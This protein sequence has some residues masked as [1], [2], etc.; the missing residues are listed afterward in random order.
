MEAGRS[1]KAKELVKDALELLP[2]ERAAFLA[3]ECADDEEL[4]R[5]AESLLG[6]A[7]GIKDLL[8]TAAPRIF[9]R[10]LAAEQQQDL[11]GQSLGRYQ[12]VAKIGA[13][14]MGEVYRAEDNRLG[15]TVAIKLLPAEFTADAERV[16][17]FE[18]EARSASALNHPN[19]ITIH[20]ID[21]V[22][23]DHGEVHF[24]VTEL[25]EGRTLR[26]LMTDTRLEVKQTIEIAAQ[27]A[28]ALR[29]VHTAWIIHRDIK[30]ENIMVRA[31]GL[32]KVLD[33]GIAKLGDKQGV[34]PSG[35]NNFDSQPIPHEGRTMNLTTAGMILGTASYMS[36]EQARGELLDGRTDVFSLGSVLYEMVTGRRLLTGTTR[37]A[38]LQSLRGDGEPLPPNA[39]FNGA[40]KGLE[41][42]VRK[43]LKQ[44]REDRYASAGELLDEFRRL[45][46]ESENR[47]QRRIIKISALVAAVALLG[48]LVA[49][50]ASVREDWIETRMRDGHR[51]GVRRAA[52]SPNGERLVSADENGVV[53]VWDFNRRELIKSLTGHHGRINSVAYEPDGRHFAT[54]GIDQTVI[55]WDAVT[56]EQAAVLREQQAPITGV[57]FSP[58]GKYL[59][60]ASDIPDARTM[61]WDTRKWEQVRDLALP[62]GDWR[63][64]LFAPNNPRTL[65]AYEKKVDVETG[66]VVEDKKN[67]IH[68]AAAF[69]AN[70]SRLVMV[71]SEG[72][73]RF[74][75]FTQRQITHKQS[76]HR[77]C[78]RAVAFSPNGKFVAT[79]AEDIVL[80]NA[81]TQEVILRWDHSSVVWGLAWS[82]D[83]QYLV[84]THG[85]GSILLWDVKGRERVA[86]LNQHIL[87]AN[88]VVFSP[89]GQRIASGSEDR[90]VIIWNAASGR[91]EAVLLG[92]QQRVNAVAFSP[93]GERFV[94]LGQNSELIG[95]DIE[96][97][98][99]RW[100]AKEGYTY[101]R[102]AFSPDGR[103]LAAAWGIH[104]S[105]NGQMNFL[106]QDC[107]PLGDTAEDVAF[108]ADGKRLATVIASG[109]GQLC[110]W[111][112]SH[113]KV[114]EHEQANEDTTVRFSPDGQRLVTGGVKGK[115]T[116]WQAAPLQKLG[117]LGQHQSR[118]K[119]V[120]FSHDGR[121]LVSVGDDGAIKLW[122]VGSRK[123]L[124][125]IGTHTAP[126]LAV[127]FSPNDQ[128][129][130]SGEQ[131]KSVRLYERRRSLWGWPLN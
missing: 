79:G 36:P 111:D 123:L 87:S 105:D 124:K 78:G 43:C 17:R 80:W 106:Y 125:E 129:I 84:S 66:Q 71:S 108:S 29:A 51:A 76:A 130:V 70:G 39:R 107:D 90:S 24:I 45:L 114:M 62:G 131:D 13:G 35:G 93:S 4:C 42:I 92:H 56:L 60:A 34:P 40:P 14:G 11:S 8:D 25:I 102:L 31:D 9:A 54:A 96:Q 104:N 99:P 73:V 47:S 121:R 61:L 16:R 109:N 120:A 30:P 119:Q 59:A 115:L 3:R 116:L 38:V 94:S 55:V 10:E 21:R 7:D 22:S 2:E 74:I 83:G 126:V 91:K 69:S 23:S 53:L 52:F 19:I 57:A 6:F 82:P 118:I 127:A 101:G 86:N 27:V 89:D 100:C 48:V 65:F 41:D 72:V 85:D 5:E 122:D 128:Q 18:Q 113:W 97:R 49:A 20:E 103:W 50:W 44:K 12:I 88:A 110:V 32:V 15:R 33:F 37:S 117:V 67:T 1:E 26:E 46:R 63:E 28:S 98:Q 112:T 77:D 64:L 68:S 75:N 58:D 95:W 81:T